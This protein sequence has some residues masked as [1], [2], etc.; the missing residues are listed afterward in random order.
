[1]NVY[2]R[3]ARDA[4]AT[5]GAAYI[6]FSLVRMMAYPEFDMYFVGPVEE[7]LGVIGVA[8]FALLTV[9]YSFAE[10]RKDGR[11][12]FAGSVANYDSE[13]GHVL[14]LILIAVALFG[15]LTYAVT[16]SMRTGSS[17]TG[18]EQAKLG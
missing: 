12:R 7:L 15:A 18:K 16:N 3:A 2:L 10:S 4:V 1:M 8:L 13:K 14:F 5:V 9:G 17:T 11:G 6:P